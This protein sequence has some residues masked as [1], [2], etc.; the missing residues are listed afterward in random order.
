[1][2]ENLLETLQDADVSSNVTSLVEDA[3]ETLEAE[4]AAEED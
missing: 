2:I 3:L 1:M 4:I